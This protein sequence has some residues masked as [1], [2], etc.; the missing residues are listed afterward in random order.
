MFLTNN[1]PAF[2]GWQVLPIFPNV[3]KIFCDLIHSH[4]TASKKRE[5][6]LSKLTFEGEF[7]NDSRVEKVYDNLDFQRGVHTFLTAMPA[8][9]LDAMRERVGSF[10]Y[11]CAQ[12]L[13]AGGAEGDRTISMFDPSTYC[14]SSPV[15]SP[16]SVLSRS[17]P[18]TSFSNVLRRI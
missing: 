12:E 9:T 15:G 13:S 14:N 1:F 3:Y 5:T 8:P 18:I 7:P 10:Y 16:G 2:Q 4:R 11:F 6:R 17:S